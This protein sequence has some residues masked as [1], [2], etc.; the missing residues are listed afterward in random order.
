MNPRIVCAANY[1]RNTGYCFISIRHF[2]VNMHNSIKMYKQAYN[3]HSVGEDCMQGFIDQ[4]GTF[5]NRTEAWPIA[6]ANG[7][8][9]R[10]VGG[11]TANGG[12]LYSE[13][14]Y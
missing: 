4:F 6:E 5:Y 11:D 3:V 1:C 8:I 14:L 13:N 7:Q 2:D 9:L 10:R 12:T